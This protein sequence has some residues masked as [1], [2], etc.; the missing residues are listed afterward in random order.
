MKE[1]ADVRLSLSD[2]FNSLE[3]RYTFA[4]DFLK[5]DEKI[6]GETRF[7]KLTFLYK[8]GNLKVKVKDKKSGIEKESSRIEKQ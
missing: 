5:G 4:S 3:S 2:V 6:K 1:K 8:F 7:L